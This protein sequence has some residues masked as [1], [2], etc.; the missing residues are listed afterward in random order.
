[1]IEAQEE[2]PLW[3]EIKEL[4]KLEKANSKNIIETMVQQKKNVDPEAIINMLKWDQNNKRSFKP[5]A[6]KWSPNI[7]RFLKDRFEKSVD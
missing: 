4:Q 6:F 2:V 5:S 7:E 1:M 3:E